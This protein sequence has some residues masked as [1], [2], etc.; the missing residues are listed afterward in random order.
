MKVSGVVFDCDGTLLDSMGAWLATQDELARR[1]GADLSKE[2]V[3][4]I[5]TLTIPETGAFMHEK[6]GLGANG[7]EV[8]DMIDALMLEYY[9]TKTRAREGALEFVKALHERGIRCSVASSTPTALLKVGLGEAGFVEYLD[10]IVSVDDAG[11]SKR[12]P[13]V[14]DLARERMGTNKE[15]TWVFEDAV[16]ALRTLTAAGYHCVGIYDNDVAGSFEELGIANLVIRDFRELSVEE[17]VEITEK[18]S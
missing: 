1:A 17:F 6:L 3:D 15:T 7:Q 11:A 12:E 2:D 16:Y 8:V 5:C 18:S 9:R 13:A 4:V 14:Y 10:A